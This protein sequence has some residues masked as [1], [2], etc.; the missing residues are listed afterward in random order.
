MAAKFC[1]RIATAHPRGRS[2]RLNVS[3]YSGV[4]KKFFLKIATEESGRVMMEGEF[5]SMSSLHQ[6]SPDFVPKPLTWEKCRIQT[7]ETYFFLC[8]F[9]KMTNDMPGPARPCAKLAELYSTS[10]SPTGMFGFHIPTCH[11]KFAQE[12][13]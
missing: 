13:A 6:T 10:Q 7:P 8:D 1:R 11:G 12:I 5:N 3:M 2:Q 9:T 4:E